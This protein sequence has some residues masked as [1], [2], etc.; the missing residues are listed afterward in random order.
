MRIFKNCFIVC[1]MSEIV[2]RLTA[3][4]EKTWTV[5]RYCTEQ[6]FCKRLDSWIWKPFELIMEE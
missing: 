6:E 1:E 2:M 3:F 5:K 4:S